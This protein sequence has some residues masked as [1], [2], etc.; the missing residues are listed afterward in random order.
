MNARLFRVPADAVVGNGKELSAVIEVAHGTQCELELGEYWVAMHFGM[1]GEPPIP[2]EEAERRGI[3]WF[4]G[5]LENV[6]FGG[7][8]LPVRG[9]TGYSRLI[10]APK[11]KQLAG[12]LETHSAADFSGGLDIDDLNNERIPPGDWHPEQ[13]EA[14]AHLYG[15]LKAFYREAAGKDQSVV[16][17]IE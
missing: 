17:V 4:E 16:V 10:P 3:E 12:L 11:V 1:T 13:L 8:A 5:S 14:L 6:L 7:D 2:R 15:G 9:P